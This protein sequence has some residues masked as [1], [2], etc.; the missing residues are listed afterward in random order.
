MAKQPTSAAGLTA[1]NDRLRKEMRRVIAERED[2]RKA[3]SFYADPERY[4][5][6]NRLLDPKV[7]DQ[8]NPESVYVWDVIRDNGAI[9]RKALGER[10]DG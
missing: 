6:P 2:A 10:D 3:L 9:A 8:W 7:V 4:R 5:G 1:D